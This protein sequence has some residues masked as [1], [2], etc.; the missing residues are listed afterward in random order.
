MDE[1]R[2]DDAARS[3][4]RVG[5]AAATRR[6]AVRALLGLVGLGAGVV[7]GS[8]DAD[9]VGSGTCRAADPSSYITKQQCNELPCGNAPG[10]LCIQTLG[11]IPHCLTGFD[12]NTPSDC[13]RRDE[14]N[15]RNPCPNGQF[16]AK[17][18]SCCPGNFR[19]CLR[20]CPA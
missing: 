1:R 6:S 3:W 10:C 16:C 9:A 19:R 12:P 14:C 20:R 7:A 4:G 17:V 5:G 15:D 2:F 8:G 13:P 11:H 18:G